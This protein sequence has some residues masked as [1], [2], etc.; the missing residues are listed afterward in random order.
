MTDKTRLNKQSITATRPGQSN[1]PIV[2]R[3][4]S[5]NPTQSL[6]QFDSPQQ[7]AVFSGKTIS[8]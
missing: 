2:D 4:H 3:S 1:P 6:K 5:T 8:P 7:F